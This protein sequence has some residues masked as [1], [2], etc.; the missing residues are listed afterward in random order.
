MTYKLKPNYHFAS[1]VELGI[2]KIPVG[3]LIIVEDYGPNHDIKWL[4]KISQSLKDDNGNVIGTLN[5]THTVNDALTYKCIEAPL[6]KKADISA[7]Y[8]M[9]E[10]DS[11][12]SSKANASDVY[13]IQDVDG[14]FRTLADSYSITEIDSMFDNAA[15]NPSGV[16]Q[17][18]AL[19]AD[20][21][22]IEYGHNAVSIGPIT[23]ANDKSVE[24]T[25]GSE[26][27]II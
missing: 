18:S 21:V 7:V 10:V 27:L 3:R 14:A 17:Q 1:T 6:D 12:V 5:S 2:D 9:T 16:I 25:D 23:I 15:V 19:I 11:M 22:I 24:I 26:W 4:R 20:N 8:S 13:T